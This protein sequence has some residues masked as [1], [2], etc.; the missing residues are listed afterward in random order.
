MKKNEKQTLTG[1]IIVLLIVIAI[2][3]YVLITKFYKKPVETG[4]RPIDTY[5][6]EN[7][8]VSTDVFQYLPPY[9]ENFHEVWLLVYFGRISNLENF[10]TQY[11]DEYYYKQPEFYANS[12]IKQGLSYYTKLKPGKTVM[13]NIGG[14]GP[15]PGDVVIKE[16]QKGETIRVS[17]F[18]HSA[19]AVVKYQGFSLVPHYPEEGKVRMGEITVKQDPQIAKNCFDI[20][21]EPNPIILE[22]TYPVFF[23]NWTRRVKAE[24]KV[25]NSCPPGWYMISIEPEKAP[26]K[27]QDEWTREYGL[28]MATIIAGGAWQIFLQVK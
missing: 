28:K 20:K 26:E 23:Y 24:I 16:I 8:C 25:R 10:S 12:F 7:G 2:F 21:I 27:Y 11:P 6:D 19:W 14:T 22:P 18:W 1:L 9:P 13:Y 17:T 15:Y 5:C 3:G 4:F